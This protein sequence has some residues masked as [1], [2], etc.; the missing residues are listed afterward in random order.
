VRA[1]EIEMI[2]NSVEG[3]ALKKDVSPEKEGPTLLRGPSGE[4]TR[5]ES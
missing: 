3:G 5:E 4:V 1:I 2:V